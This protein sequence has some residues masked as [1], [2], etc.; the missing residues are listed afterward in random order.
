MKRFVGVLLPAVLAWSLLACGGEA[1]PAPAERS[2][3]AE[4]AVEQPAPEPSGVTAEPEPAGP[5]R[6]TLVGKGRVSGDA[7]AP[8]EVTLELSYGADNVIEGTLA[9]GGATR[10]VGGVLDGDRVRC[11]L[12]DTAEGAVQRGMLVGD[13][14]KDGGFIGSFAVSTDGAAEALTGTWE[15]TAK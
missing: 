3:A 9:I 4:P 6:T 5:A 13:A 12:R 7:G 10:A 8:Q 11:W 14:R 15:A 2:G 1:E